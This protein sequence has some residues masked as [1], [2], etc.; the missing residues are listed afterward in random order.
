MEEIRKGFFLYVVLD[1]LMQLHETFTNLIGQGYAL[2]NSTPLNAPV[3]TEWHCKN[4]VKV[5]SSWILLQIS[6][7][8]P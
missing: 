3:Q 7:L 4:I 8:Q 2:E 6:F 5:I 1:W